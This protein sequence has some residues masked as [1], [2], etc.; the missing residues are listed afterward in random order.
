[1]PSASAR[2]HAEDPSCSSS[3]ENPYVESFSRRLRDEVLAVE[4]FNTVLEARVL[5][6]D[7]RIE[8]NL[9]RRAALGVPVRLA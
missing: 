5:V 8:Y 1:M 6:N 9:L 2:R 7:W 3:W 4:A